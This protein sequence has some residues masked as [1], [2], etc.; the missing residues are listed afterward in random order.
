MEAEAG[1]RD[2][3][4]AL[5]ALNKALEPDRSPRHEPRFIQR[6]G[7]TYGL[8]MEETWVDADAFEDLIV[9]GNHLLLGNSQ[10]AIGYYQMA[11]TLYRGDYL[12][13]RQYEDW[14][15]AE[16]ERLQLL[17]LG[18]MTTLAGL[19]I[20]QSPLESIRLAQQVLTVDPVWEDAYRTQMRAY[21]AQGNRPLALRTYQRC[22]EMLVQELGIEPLPETQELYKQI[23]TS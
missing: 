19:L 17:A 20:E 16:R 9:L 21:L 18:T 12:P 4:V 8:N 23:I 7:L 14:T 11:L 10:A 1:D 6:Q 13:D 5:H 22:V 15:S 3:K 2:F